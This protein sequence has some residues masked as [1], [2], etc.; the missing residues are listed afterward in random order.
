MRGGAI[1]TASYNKIFIVQRQIIWENMNE[2]VCLSQ[3]KRV[4]MHVAKL[5]A[6]LCNVHTSYAFP[7]FSDGFRYYM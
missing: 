7:K 3:V 5:L 2:I 4:D 6:H 1:A